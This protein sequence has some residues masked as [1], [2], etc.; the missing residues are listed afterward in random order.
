[1]LAGFGDSIMKGVMLRSAVKEGRP[2]YELSK[3][4][5][6]ERCGQQL[7]T[8]VSNFARFGC[9]APMGEKLVDRY[10]SRLNPDETVLIGYGGND[11]DYDWEAIADLP[12]DMHLPRTP[13]DTFIAAYRNIISKIRHAGAIP[14]MLTM[15]P[16][17]AERYFNFFTRNL[18]DW[19]KKNILSWLGGTTD[20]IIKGHNIY[21][22]AIRQIADE[23][24][25][26]LLDITSDF[27]NLQSINSMLCNDGIHPNEDGQAYIT[28]LI[29][30]QLKPIAA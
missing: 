4:S 17:D 27:N 14:V 12:D 10:E 23:Q 19:H 8:P 22:D 26:R 24:N 5:I 1:M 21:N 25:V 30:S 11:S 6:I 13:L 7:G 3:Q 2:E 20:T 9:T 29:V 18:S 16:M 28:N 15:P